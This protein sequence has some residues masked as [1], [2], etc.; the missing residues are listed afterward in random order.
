VL[1]RSGGARSPGVGIAVND[2]HDGD[3]LAPSSKYPAADS[4]IRT[5]Y[6]G[7]PDDLAIPVARFTSTEIVPALHAISELISDFPEVG[8]ASVRE[9][10]SFVVARYGTTL[11]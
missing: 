11:I 7:I 2:W 1:A 9:E 3:R 4:A 10:L 5:G 6:G 8:A